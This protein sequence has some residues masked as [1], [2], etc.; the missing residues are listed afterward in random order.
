MPDH[1]PKPNGRPG[2]KYSEAMAESICEQ[3]MCGMSMVQVCKQDGMPSRATVIRWFTQ[4]PGF[5]A[6]CTHA[7]SLQADLMDDM[8]L[9]V[10]NQ[11]DESNYQS[12]RVKL[13]ALQWRASKLAPKKYGDKVDMNL[14]GEVAIKRVV[15]D[16]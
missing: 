3:I 1:E 10:A 14:T 16:I 12:S 13:S 5:E 15:S 4:Q 8:I 2:P 6:R 11:C 7:R 9:D